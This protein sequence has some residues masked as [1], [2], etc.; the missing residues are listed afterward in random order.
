MDDFQALE[1]RIAAALDRIK[2]GLHTVDGS[3]LRQLEAALE[4]ER[5][6]KGDLETRLR[7]VRGSQDGRVADLQDELDRQQ[8]MFE[9]DADRLRGEIAKRDDA[10]DA[11]KA[12]MSKMRNSAAQQDAGSGALRDELAAMQA[13]LQQPGRH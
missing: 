5:A 2:Q 7:D 11:V 13:E 8:K 12:D 3:A 10:I 9:A 6:A 1:G 4:G